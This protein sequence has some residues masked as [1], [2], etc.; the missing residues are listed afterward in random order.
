MCNVRIINAYRTY[1]L[2]QMLFHFCAAMKSILFLWEKYLI[3]FL[4]LCSNFMGRERKLDASSHKETSKV[5]FRIAKITDWTFAD[6]LKLSQW[7]G[8]IGARDGWHQIITCAAV[9]PRHNNKIPGRRGASDGIPMGSERERET[10][11][12][13]RSRRGHRR[14]WQF[15]TPRAMTLA[16]RWGRGG[17]R[18]RRVGHAIA[19]EMIVARVK[20][21]AS[22]R[23]R[24]RKAEVSDY[25]TRLA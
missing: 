15:A 17:S 8:P 1:L 20:R 11:F 25:L 6:R 18:D 7:Q 24:E 22:N 14:A 4:R 3:Y 10:D 5:A 9:R 19:P 12:C 23:T 2:L 13:L 21:H 16:G